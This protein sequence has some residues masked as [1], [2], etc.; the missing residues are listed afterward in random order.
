MWR[1]GGQSNELQSSSERVERS[2]P[3]KT[4]SHEFVLSNALAREILMMTGAEAG[5]VHV[6]QTEP[7]VTELPQAVVGSPPS[8]VAPARVPVKL[9]VDPESTI[10]SPKLSLAGGVWE[11]VRMTRPP[12]ATPRTR[13]RRMFRAY[14]NSKFSARCALPLQ[15][16]T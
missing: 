11:K 13:V 8:R 4:S 9:I 14:Q 15:E 12:A 10:R 16:T 1:P 6:H 3:L 5:A 7:P 2:G